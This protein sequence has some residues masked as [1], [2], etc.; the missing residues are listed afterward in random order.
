MTSIGTLKSEFNR[1]YV[2]L[3]PNIYTGPPA[4]RL[5]NIPGIN[6]RDTDDTIQNLYTLAPITHT[7][8][9]NAVELKFDISAIEKMY[10]ILAGNHIN[11]SSYKQFN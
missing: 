4:W 7:E 5:S 6:D 2:Y 8:N 11:T 3:N 9:G 10:L 1:T